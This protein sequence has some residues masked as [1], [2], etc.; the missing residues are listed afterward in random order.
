MSLKPLV[1][2]KES[3]V[4]QALI[5]LLLVTTFFG[6]LLRL[7]L[8]RT[9]VN[10]YLSDILIVCI[11]GWFMYVVIRQKIKI[12]K[13]P[14]LLPLLTFLGVI[15]LSWLVNFRLTSLDQ[16][17]V[18][19][20][21][22]FRWTLY[23]S[24]VF[25]VSYLV[26]A[27]TEVKQTL[28]RT[29]LALIV[30]FGVLGVLQ[31]WFMADF[32]WL[33]YWGW[34]PH[35]HRL[36]STWLDPGYAGLVLVFGLL[37]IAPVFKQRIQ[38]SW[39]QVV[40]IWLIV[41]LG[42]TFSRASYLSLMTGVV[43]LSLVLRSWRILVLYAISLLLVVLL[44]P[45]PAGEGVNL[46]RTSTVNFRVQNWQ[47]A[48]RVIEDY[49]LTGVG[50]N[51]YRYVRTDYVVDVP[52][53]WQSSHSGAGV[54]NSWLFIMATTGF[55]GFVAYGFYWLQVIMHLDLLSIP[56][57]NV[58][59]LSD[60]VRYADQIAIGVLAAWGVHAYFHNS[61]FYIPAITVASMLLGIA[62]A[63]KYLGG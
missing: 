10:L 8:W 51:R 52:A 15:S 29:L 58:E 61:L 57:G 60:L 26:Y 31:Y 46:A 21:Y 3:E 44:I 1:F 30:G 24:L 45:K 42:L 55:I 37:M 53:D 16:F 38:Y 27:R 43:I 17:I 62:L 6:Q 11:F 22:L 23:T 18:S 5:Q 63:K 48:L 59:K 54:D 4:L 36:A 32:H 12:W 33:Q 25:T 7:P 47:E 19:V 41:C 14:L 13:H 20:M 50:F 34:D 35:L 9:D 49:P 56:K 28:Y 39:F 40:F 2:D